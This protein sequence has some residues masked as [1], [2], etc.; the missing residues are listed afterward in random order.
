MS[1][2]GL[3]VL[4]AV[5]AFAVLTM[6]CAPIGEVEDYQLS[7]EQPNVG[8]TLISEFGPGYS[9][10]RLVESP[11]G[12]RYTICY[13]IVSDQQTDAEIAMSCN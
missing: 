4:V 3:K 2:Y 11:F 5:L 12:G 8:I 10:Y 1:K 9:A 6:S 13:I 7:G